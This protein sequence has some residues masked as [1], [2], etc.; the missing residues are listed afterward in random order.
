MLSYIV[1]KNIGNKPVFLPNT[2]SIPVYTY[3]QN[4]PRRSLL[5]A[6]ADE[7]KRQ[8]LVG[9]ATLK[10]LELAKATF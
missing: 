5:I 6:L 1:H 3:V 2:F 4:R 7:S 9:K 10:P 8:K